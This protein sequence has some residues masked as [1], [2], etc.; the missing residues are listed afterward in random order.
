MNFSSRGVYATAGIPGTGLSYRQRIDGG[1]VGCDS[2]SGRKMSGRQLLAMIRKSELDDKIKAVQDQINKE[3]ADYQAVIKYWQALPPIPTPEDFV[4]ALGKQPFEPDFYP[5]EPPDWASM[6]A[7]LMADVTA[8]FKRQLSFRFL[9]EVFARRRAA[10]EM[11]VRWT[12]REAQLQQS[13]EDGCGEFNER[14]DQETQ[15]WDQQEADRIVRV[16]KL[17]SG[18]V[19]ETHST[20]LALIASLHFPFHTN[21]DVFLE[22]LGSIYLHVELP[23]IEGTILTTT[24]KVLKTGEV[25]EVRRSSQDRNNDYRQLVLG[26][27]VYLAAELFASL[28]LTETARIAAYTHRLRRLESDP[29]DTYVLDVPFQRASVAAAGPNPEN[30]TALVAKQG[31]R[32][33]LGP[34]GEL[35]R[36]EPPSWL[37]HEDLAQARISSMTD[38]NLDC[39]VTPT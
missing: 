34:D 9:P 2:L 12:E 17:L 15:A 28:P 32:M 31:G 26:Q 39:G 24:K 22:E 23:E 1:G 14:L 20:A 6:Q 8:Q 29:I 25:R 35:D 10:K 27:C 21:C 7:K 33:Q 36:I 13:Y 4:K 5:P 11:P 16:Q 30:L 18:D 38:N 19:E 37:T 3:W